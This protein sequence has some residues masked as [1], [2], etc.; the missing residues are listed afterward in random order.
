MTTETRF[1]DGKLH[2]IRTYDAPREAVFEA[3]VETHKVEQWWGCDQTVAVKSE[4]ECKVGGKYAHTMT[5]EGAGE[6]PGAGTFTAYDP[7]ARI[8]W[9]MP[10][11]VEPGAVMSVSVDFTEVEGGTR[12]HLIHAGI[13]D[14]EVEGGFPLREIIQ[15][16]WSAA[17]GK[18]HGFL[19]AGV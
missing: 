14:M 13:P 5:I 9:E 7:P 11:P 19:A 16:G 18:L 8:A 1:E 15:G 17:F 12:V 3:W 6:H 4:I 10:S 2:V